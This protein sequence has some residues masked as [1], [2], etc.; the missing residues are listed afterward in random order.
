MTDQSQP[1]LR[2]DAAWR[3]AKDEIGKRNDAA[4]KAGA[5]RRE[6]EDERAADRQRDIDR[7]EMSNLPTQ[8]DAS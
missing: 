6:R 7:R 2:G 4:R 3:A 1:P 8:P 5:A